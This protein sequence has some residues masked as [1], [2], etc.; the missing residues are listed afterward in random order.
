MKSLNSKR[1]VIRSL[2][3]LTA[4]MALS[5]QSPEAHAQTFTLLHTFTGAADD[6]DYPQG[7]P[8]RDPKGNLYGVALG[9][10][11]GRGVVFKVSG[12]RQETV[13][14]SFTGLSDGDIPDSISFDDSV[15]SLFGTTYQGGANGFGTVFTLDAEGSET[16]V[17][18]FC[19][20]KPCTAGAFPV[21]GVIQDNDN[22]YGIT[23]AG[24]D[25]SCTLTGCGTVF[26]INRKG[27]QTGL[28]T[29]TGSDGDSPSGQ[30]VRDKSGNL[31]GATAFGGAY[32]YGTVFKLAATGQESV[33][34]SFSGA[35]DGSEPYGGL[36]QDA[37]GNLYG[38][39]SQGG[40][41]NYG[42][43][44]KV[45]RLGEYVV[46]HS[47]KGGSLGAFP[48]AGVITDEQGNIFGTTYQG[49]SDNYGTVFKIDFSGDLTMLHS[50][51]GKKDG[52]YP[53]GVIKDGNGTLYGTTYQGGA[54]NYGTVFELGP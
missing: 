4:A 23:V 9:G 6:G 49:G 7:A 13:L 27:I 41:Y 44:F 24:G 50:F 54:Y 21:G 42:T 36:S 20:S 34:Y 35:A 12:T 17:Y 38:T 39:T 53:Y 29:F 43:V 5:T 31:Y 19:P 14:Y 32:G 48:Y 52:A 26:E 18:S 10:T 30:I 8:V 37:E 28:H 16:V 22:L 2:C 11:F 47:F 46:L 15:D 1:L 25:F 33:I 51:S 3:L 40:E 45:T